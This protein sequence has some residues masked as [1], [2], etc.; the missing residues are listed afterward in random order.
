MFNAFLALLL[1]IFK[2]VVTP[3][4]TVKAKKLHPLWIHV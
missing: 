2:C 4:V 3:R 1:Q